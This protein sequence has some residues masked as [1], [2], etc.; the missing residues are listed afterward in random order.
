MRITGVLT[1]TDP[2]DSLHFVQDSSGGIFIDSKQK[3]FESFPESQQFVE[4][5]GFSGPGDFAPV[6][7]SEQLQVLGEGAFP[8][9]KSATMQTLITGA[10]DSQ[11]ISLNGV[12]RSQSVVD[13]ATILS[14]AAGDFILQV[15]VPGA[16]AHPAPQNYADAFVEIRGVCATVFDNERRVQSIKLLVPNWEQVR[17]LSVGTDD[18]F[19]LPVRSISE[20]LE[21]HAGAEGLHRAHV[22]GTVVLR[23]TDHS[24]YLQDATGGLLIQ[25]QAAP[26]VIAVG[27]MVELVGF[28]S[29]VNKLPVLQE[30]VVRA[31]TEKS[32][33]KPAIVMPET[34]FSQVLHGNLV[35]LQARVIS[36]SSSAAEDSLTLQFGPWI[37]DA[38]LERERPGQQLGRIEPGATVDLIGVYLARLDD[39]L[40][41]QSFQLLLR[42][43]NDVQVLTHPSWWTTQRIFWLLGALGIAFALILAW[44]TSLRKQVSERTLELRGEIEE[45]K[46]MEAQVTQTHREL[47]VASRRA[48]MAEVATTVLHNVGNVLNSVNV[49]A[50]LVVEATKNSKLSGL[51]KVSLLLRE[52]AG[53]LPS[54]LMEDPKGRQLPDYLEMLA[55]RHRVEQTK[56]LTELESLTGNINHIKEIV[57]RQQSNAKAIGI[58]EIV[59]VADLIEEALQMNRG[60]LDRHKVSVVRDFAPNLPPI[61]IDKHKVLQILVNLISNAKHACDESSRPDKSLIVR[62]AQ[63]GDHLRIS[64]VDNGVGIASG[65]YDPHL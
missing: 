61:T 20:L 26:A 43:A 33:L 49:S 2:H 30:A 17:T 24:F 39:S 48:G 29:I 31:A 27:Q 11:W 58:T 42:S 65:K 28:P 37:L 50:N 36:S 64:I 52:H 38:M 10:E 16:S 35:R 41:V 44:I 19:A 63:A 8:N 23:R 32:T 59:E 56:V 5:T 14:L 12:V 47:L 7:Q 60:G 45:R 55:E 1:Y 3:K 18:P 4:I 62:T 6:I 53:D 21:F 22:R 57:A 54:F 15:T 13:D 40:K 25:S 51:A 46:R 9:P 34:P